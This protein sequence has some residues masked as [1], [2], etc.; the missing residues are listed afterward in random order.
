MM[1]TLQNGLRIV[2]VPHPSEVVYCGYVVCAGTRNEVAEDF[3]LAHFIEHLSFKGTERRRAW[4]IN[5]YLE[6]VGG[7]LNAFTNKQETVYH[8]TVLRQDFARAA[9]LLT[10]IVFHSQYPEA[11][12]HR[13]AE[14]VCDEIDSYEDSPAERIFDEFEALLF[15]GHP[16]GRDILGTKERVRAYRRADAQRFTRCWYTPDNA[17]FF[18]LGNVEEKAVVR[19]I[20]RLT[21]DLSASVMERVAQPLPPYRPQRVERHRDTH[22]AHVILGNRAQGGYSEARFA[23]SLL[24][25]ILGGPGMNSRL[26]ARL[27][28]KAGL[29]YTA[30]SYIYMYPDVGVWEVYF[31]CDKADVNRCLHLVRHELKRFVDE[32]LTPARL[33]AAKS[34][35]IGQIGIGEANLEGLALTYGKTLA[36]YDT[37]HNPALLR[38][39]IAALSAAEL[40]AAA[41]ELFAPEQISTLIYD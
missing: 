14:V 13:E 22:Q 9:D 17:V 21:S 38:E 28:E 30:D 3:G 40:Q 18:C 25:N 2:V 27:R 5:N 33:K 39:R 29:V 7:D 31:G 16:L 19:R 8:A 36:H 32:R 23:V 15:D 35:F 20:E 4:H 12:L 37:L 41:A 1:T 11:E 10:D 24:S 6:R 34:Q 26:T